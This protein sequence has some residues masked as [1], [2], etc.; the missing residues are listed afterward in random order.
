ML[1]NAT[2]KKITFTKINFVNLIIILSILLGCRKQEGVY[3]YDLVSAFEGRIYHRLAK[4]LITSESCLLDSTFY[5]R[6]LSS[7]GKDVD[8]HWDF[9]DGSVSN[10]FS[11]S[12]K[13]RTSGKYRVKLTVSLKSGKFAVYEKEL[14]VLAGQKRISMG[15]PMST[16]IVDLVETG[17]DRFTLFGWSKDLSNFPAPE[18]ALMIILDRDLRKVLQVNF[19]RDYRFGAASAAKDG[20]FVVCGTTSGDKLNNE[21]LKVN[22]DGKILWSKKMGTD[23]DFN[24]ALSIADGYLLT[25]TK[26]NQKGKLQL[27]TVKTDLSGNIIRKKIYDDI[28][29][30]GNPGNTIQD[31]EEYVVGGLSRV[32]QNV[33]NSCDSL[34][35]IK[36]NSGGVVVNKITIPMRSSTKDNSKVYISRLDGGGYAVAASRASALYTFTDNLTPVLQTNVSGEI[37][38]LNTIPSGQIL[39]LQQGYNNGFSAGYVGLDH[40]G[41]RLWSNGFDGTE[42]IP[43]GERCCTNSWGVK[44]YPLRKGGSVFILDEVGFEYDYRIIVTKLNDDGTLM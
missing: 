19:S 42:E 13:Y 10:E 32:D 20:N 24:H 35:L 38:H 4:K 6:N 43:D 28:V 31:G 12:H 2:L 3:P 37:T 9:G 26:R 23:E 18:S 1:N 14:S 5:F 41:A 22:R 40:R 16:G 25:G 34:S 7:G 39:L 29:N 30:L 27:I 15:Y 44:T 36:F 33:C 8:Q 21:L 17:D 11:P